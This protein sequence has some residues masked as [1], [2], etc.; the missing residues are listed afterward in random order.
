MYFF[1]LI[2]FF[3]IK[4]IVLGGYILKVHGTYVQVELEKREMYSMLSQHLSTA[5]RAVGYSPCYDSPLAYGQWLVLLIISNSAIARFVYHAFPHFQEVRQSR[6]GQHG[7]FLKLNKPIK[8]SIPWY[9]CISA[10]PSS[11]Q[12][13]S[14]VSFQGTPHRE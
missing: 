2:F 9:N 4:F 7:S 13:Q 5:T 3:L 10:T 6:V 8:N 12:K 11:F 14:S 1:F